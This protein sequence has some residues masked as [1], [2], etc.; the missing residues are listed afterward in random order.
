M[1]EWIEVRVADRH[2]VARDI[3]SF[4]LEPVAAA[5]LP[6][7]TAGAH[8]DVEIPNGLMRQYSLCGPQ[9]EVGFYQIGVLRDEKGR[10]GS[11]AIHDQVKKGDLLRISPPRNLF[12]LVE[13]EQALL[14]AGGIG[15]TPILAMAECL[16]HQGIDFALHYCVRSGDRAAFRDRL[17]AAAL[18]DKV[19]LHCDDQPDTLLDATKVLAAPQ[20]GKHLYVCGPE[21]FMDHVLQTARFVGWPEHKIHYERFAPVTADIGDSGDFELV[22]EGREGSIPVAAG[23]TALDALLNAGIEL[24]VSCEQG[25][26]GTC[27]TDVIDGIPDHRD[28]YLS[29]AERAANDCFTPC[30]SRSLTPRLTIRI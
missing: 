12:P 24:P 19:T 28:M 18:A 8:I 17:K 26:C 23:Q 2:D 10:G 9:G 21:G 22:V 30:C 25:I 13:Q 27:L 7:W 4:H 3:T 15:I 6:Q 16:V 20:P 29:E 1:T 5:E 14:F 11:R